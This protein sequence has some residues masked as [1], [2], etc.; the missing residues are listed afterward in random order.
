MKKGEYDELKGNETVCI[1]DGM[2]V[3]KDML[4]NLV[5]DNPSPITLPLTPTNKKTTSLAST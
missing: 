3:T 1:L 5:L 2:K 4:K